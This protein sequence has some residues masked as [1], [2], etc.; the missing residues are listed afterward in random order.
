[1]QAPAKAG[2]T[3]FMVQEKLL[4]HTREVDPATLEVE[5]INDL[6]RFNAIA[7]EWD[8]LVDRSGLERL[9]VSHAWLR[10]WWEAFGGDRQLYVLTVRSHQELIGAAPMMRSTKGLYG[11]RV[12]SIESIYN[13]HTPRCDFIV[14]RARARVVYD[15]IWDHLRQSDCDMIVLTQLPEDSPTLSAFEGFAQTDGWFSGQW[16]A[17]RSP[18]IP[19]NCSYEELLST[20]KGG[21]RYNLRK[22]YERLSKL[23]TID[24][25]VISS[26]D[27]VREATDEGLRIEAAAWKGQHG[28]AIISDPASTEFYTRLAERE[29]DLGQLR[30]CFL[31][32]GGKRISFSYI[33]C[34]DKKLYGVKI[35]YDPEYHTYSPGNMLLNLVLQDACASQLLEYDFLGV[36]DEWKLDWTKSSRGHRWLFLF[37]NRFRPRLLHYLKFNV[38]PTIKPQLGRLCTSLGYR[39]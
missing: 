7:A 26:K 15:A 24:V 37:R 39:V 6:E 10:T 9:F 30:L 20:L 18:Y 3:V 8:E 34:S 12:K 19:L 31:R 5:V 28:T 17:A 13:P 27:R 38:V 23:G 14:E 36:D 16:S 11:V 2:A 22:R 33:L 4:T 29:A 25:E 32:I 1:M 35:G 21:Y